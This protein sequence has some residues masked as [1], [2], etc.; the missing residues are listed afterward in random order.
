LKE[1]LHSQILKKKKLA[2]FQENIRSKTKIAKQIFDHSNY[3]AF[4]DEPVIIQPSFDFKSFT[5][6]PIP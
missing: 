6:V 3:E 1:E 2:K 5:P 4:F